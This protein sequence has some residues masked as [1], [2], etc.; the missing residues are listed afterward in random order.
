MLGFAS[1]L[2]QHLKVLLESNYAGTKITPTGFMKALVENNP[3]LRISS[4]NG[5]S[6]EGLKRSTASGHIRDVR[7]KYLPRITPD[8]ISDYDNCENDF[9]FQYS[10]T[11]LRTPLFSKAGFQLEWG[12]VERYKEEASRLVSLGSTPDVVVLN[13][14]VEQIM[15]T[16]NGLVANMDGKLLTSVVWGINASTGLN[17]AKT[18]N[19]NKDGSVF[20][21]SDGVT[22]ILHDASV[23]EIIGSPIIV[24]SGLMNK[25]E[26]AKAATGVNGGGLNR[27]LQSGYDWYYD[28][29][30]EFVWG[31]DHVGVFAKGTVGLVDIDRYIAWKTGRHGTSEFAQITLPIETTDGTPQTMTFNLQI[32][33]LDCPAE[34]FDGYETR[35]MGRGYQILI[36]KNF[37]LFQA[38]ID[39]YSAT[40]QLA[41]NNGAL[42]YNVTNDCDSCT[43]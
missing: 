12:F 10:E 15:H 30:S 7:L 28:R 9:G 13:E 35:S 22:E 31:T 43:P 24:G 2:L 26:I 42:L 3:S 33:E 41:G 4:V 16:V 14:M 1:S 25:Y 19:I 18:I 17:T 6:I 5:D 8:Q 40:D 38:P 27:S 32:R 21:L 36:S 37:G 34:A 23:N 29:P 20:D 11:E 39:Q